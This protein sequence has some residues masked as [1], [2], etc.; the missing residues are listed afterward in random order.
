MAARHRDQA[1]AGAPA[2]S[3]RETLIGTDSSPSACMS[4][5]RSPSARAAACSSALV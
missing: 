4:S 5:S 1:A 2:C 3:S